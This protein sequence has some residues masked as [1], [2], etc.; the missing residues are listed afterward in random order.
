MIEVNSSKLHYGQKRN[1]DSFYQCGSSDFSGCGTTTGTCE[2]NVG[3][4]RRTNV[5]NAVIVAGARAKIVKESLAATEQDR[6]NCEMHFIDERSTKILP[7]GGC[8]A[9]NKNIAVTR[10][11]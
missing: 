3:N 8:A 1:S 9:A 4:S 5:L 2:A 7:D 11:V 10:C 6:Y